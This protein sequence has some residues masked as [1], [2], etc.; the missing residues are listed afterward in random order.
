MLHLRVEFRQKELFRQ[1]IKERTSGSPGVTI[2]NRGSGYTEPR[3]I[4]SP[5][6]P[7]LSCG[8]P[9]WWR[10]SALEDHDDG[11]I[12]H[13]WDVSGN[14][15]ITDFTTVLAVSQQG[16]C[17]T[18]DQVA[19]HDCRKELGGGL[20]QPHFVGSSALSRSRG[21]HSPTRRT[22]ASAG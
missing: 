16:N 1:A 18:L 2:T 6:I 17:G 12:E 3:G 5:P 7:V 4:R 14:A 13:V 21:C 20:C 10:A 11:V 19:D 9:G 15:P 8:M 22:S